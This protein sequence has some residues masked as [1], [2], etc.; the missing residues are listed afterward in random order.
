MNSFCSDFLANL[1]SDLLV[2]LL[3]GSLLAQ[4]V[5]KRISESE[6]IQQTRDERRAKLEKTTVYL[7]LLRKEI[8][9]LI[10]GIPNDIEILEAKRTGVAM[11]LVPAIWDVLRP[12]G[13]LPKLVDPHLLSSI[14]AFYSHVAVARRGTD[15]TLESW[16]TPSASRDTR[17]VNLAKTGLE[18]ALQVGKTLPD[19][20]D[21][22]IKAIED[23]IREL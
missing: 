18:S 13:E 15:L 20:I 10:Q 19:R 5:G 23:Q 4:W 6:R 3:L 7:N 16:L 14:A 17:F 21:L 12:S 8:A 11:V 22:E 1:L 9:D 2:G